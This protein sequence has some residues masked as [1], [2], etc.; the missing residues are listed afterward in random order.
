M[1]LLLSF[2]VSRVRFVQPHETQPTRPLPLEECK[3]CI[4]IQKVHFFLSRR[5]KCPFFPVNRLFL[6]Q[7]DQR[8]FPKPR[9]Q[10]P[11][12]E[13][14]NRNESCKLPSANL[15]IISRCVS[16]LLLAKEA[17]LHLHVLLSPTSC[18]ESMTMLWSH[19]NSYQSHFCAVKPSTWLSQGPPQ[20][21]HP[22]RISAAWVWDLRR[23][24]Q[25]VQWPVPHT[26]SLQQMSLGWSLVL[27]HTSTPRTLVNKR[28][29]TFFIWF[30]PEV[31]EVVEAINCTLSVTLSQCLYTE[32]YWIK[33]EAL[34]SLWK[35]RF[36]KL[37]E[38]P[39]QI[40]TCLHL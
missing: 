12:P 32:C 4:C 5:K 17:S 36:W 31:S 26:L 25:E 34:L 21:Q 24:G 29:Q 10:K 18:L 27:P 20:S 38:S 14:W 2:A 40:F 13:T 9:E 28:L 37:I 8:F 19:G 35:P 33:N 3:N 16:V 23:I 11:A 30:P 15:S 6:S 22:W 39:R 1:L 7:K